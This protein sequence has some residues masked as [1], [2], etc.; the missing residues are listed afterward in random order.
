MTTGVDDGLCITLLAAPMTS[1]LALATEGMM[2]AALDDALSDAL[3]AL[4]WRAMG[5][6]A[7][8][9]CSLPV[10]IVMYMT[11]DVVGT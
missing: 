7:D 8:D 4:Q 1:A 6:N 3:L 10:I 11:S 2:V 5:V 9:A